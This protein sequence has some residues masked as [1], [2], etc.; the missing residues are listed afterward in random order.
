KEDSGSEETKIAK[1]YGVTAVFP[2]PHESQTRRW[3]YDPSTLTERWDE[4][5]K[6]IDRRLQVNWSGIQS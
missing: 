1:E 2:K 3:V 6:R 5:N 4:E